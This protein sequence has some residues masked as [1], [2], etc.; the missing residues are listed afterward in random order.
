MNNNIAFHN[1]SYLQDKEPIDRIV[2]DE[3]IE[4]IF[5]KYYR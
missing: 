3:Q 5:E 2:T 4:W 1:K